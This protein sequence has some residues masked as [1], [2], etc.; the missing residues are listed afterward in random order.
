[1]DEGEITMTS[2]CLIRHGETDWN[3]EGRVQGQTDIPLNETGIS[4]AKQCGKIL[5]QS[6]WDMIITSPL[7]RAKQ[8]ATIIN[9]T[10][11]LPMIEMEEF[12]ERNYG[13]VEGMTVEERNK[14]YPNRNYPNQETQL[15]LTDRVMKGIHKINE[16]Y[17]NKKILLVAH[18]GVIN[19]ILSHL[20][21]GEIGSGKTKLLNA[22]LS[23]IYLTEEKWHIKDYNQITHLTNLN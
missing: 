2:I 11:Q 6:T 10:L 22:C 8:S 12:K 16:T 19:A 9:E 14:L 23:N 21:D 20:S 17:Y 5:Q 13:D 18:G 3:K 1:M 15:E 4:Q 7:Q